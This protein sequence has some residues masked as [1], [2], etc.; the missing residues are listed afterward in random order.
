[1]SSEVINSPINILTSS[2]NVKGEISANGDFRLDG[3]LDGSLTTTGKLVVG[4]SGLIKGDVVCVNAN[5]MGVI[6]GNISVKETLMLYASAH[7]KGDIICDRLAIEA[8]AQF[9]GS[10]RMLDELREQGE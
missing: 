9:S 10:C 8:G 7:V 5:V 3:T 1:M 6:E 2:T 4:E